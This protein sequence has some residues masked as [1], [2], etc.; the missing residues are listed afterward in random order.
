MAVF[1]WNLMSCHHWYADPHPQVTSWIKLVIRPQQQWLL[2]EFSVEIL[3]SFAQKG[4]WFWQ[5]QPFLTR[6]IHS[7]EKIHVGCPTIDHVWCVWLKVI[8]LFW[9]VS[10][11]LRNPFGRVWNPNP[12]RMT[13]TSCGG[14]TFTRYPPP[15]SPYFL[16]IY[17]YSK[18]FLKAF[19]GVMFEN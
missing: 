4:R 15:Q 1:S 9:R 19:C 18:C 12:P 8:S 11:H 6:L 3:N 17:W 10:C 7:L 13:W 5:K 2:G 14:Y 16:T